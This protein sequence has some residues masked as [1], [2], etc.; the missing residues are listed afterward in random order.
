M[1]GHRQRSEKSCS[2]SHTNRTPSMP[3][4]ITVNSLQTDVKLWFVHKHKIWSSFTAISC[5]QSSR[6]IFA[7]R[8]QIINRK[9]KACRRFWI[10]MPSKKIE[11]KVKVARIRKKHF[12]WRAPPKI[13]FAFQTLIVLISRGNMYP[14]SRI[15]MLHYI[16]PLQFLLA[17]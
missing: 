6:R 12:F 2:L 10:K 4:Q 13:D 3:S 1:N 7:V 8:L 14:I 15:S 5:C 16:V 11:G 9:Y 17:W